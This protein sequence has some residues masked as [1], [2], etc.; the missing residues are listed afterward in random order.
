MTLARG[1]EPKAIEKFI[2]ELVW[3]EYWQEVYWAK[4]S[5]I[6]EDLRSIQKDVLH[7]EI[8]TAILEAKTGIQAI[9]EAIETFYE[10]GYLHN[11]VRMYIA[12]IACN[13]GKSHWKQPARW[14][15]YHLLDGDWASNTLSWQWVAGTN[16]SKKY[17]A[18]QD[19]I[20]RFCYT[21]QKD[22]FLDHS[23]EYLAKMSCPKALE[24][25]EKLQLETNLPESET[26]KIDAQIP[27]LIY[28]TY[29]L[30]PRW[31]AD[32]KA[33]RI[34]ILEPEHLEQYPISERVLNFMLELSE[35]IPNLQI[36]V[37]S[38]ADL[39][40]EYQLTDIHFKK[41]PFTSH[42]QGKSSEYDKI[43]DIQGDFPSFFRYWNKGKK[44]VDW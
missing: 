3:R 21:N 12:A 15:Y 8:P 4:G 19:N 42:F 43:F 16:S 29:Q 27:T 40:K 28:T 10:T 20:N 11:H 1:F 18:N 36:Y 44:T 30:D 25:T 32:I 38:Y 33:N 35:N 23:Y 41:H 9:D 34:L 5:E 13:M 6:E 37:G 14:M 31:K 7:H 2:Q 22:S 26:L 17:L 39:L 24:A